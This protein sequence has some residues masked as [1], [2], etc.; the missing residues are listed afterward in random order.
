ML[1]FSSNLFFFN[2]A[3]SCKPV[4][5][6]LHASYKVTQDV[7]RHQ[8]FSELFNDFLPTEESEREVL[9]SKLI[10]VITIMGER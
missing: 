2:H 9:H 5:T 10:L 3:E 7:D 8:H 6:R 4:C 1:S